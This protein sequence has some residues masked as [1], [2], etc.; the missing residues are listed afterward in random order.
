VDII[1]SQLAI[2]TW[3]Q[4]FRQVVPDVRLITPRPDGTWSQPPGDR[5][6]CYLDSALWRPDFSV[7]FLPKLATLPSLG[8]LHTFMHG[9]DDPRFAALLARGVQVTRS[10]GAQ[11]PPI[12]QYVLGMMLRVA[13]QMDRWTAAQARREWTPHRSQE[14]T[15]QTLGL[16]GLGEIGREIA[17]LAQALRMRVIGTRRTPRPT[18]HVDEVLP[19][20]R[21]HELL[22]RA[23]FVV[24]AAALTPETAGMIGEAELRAISPTAWLI[25]VARGALIREEILVRALRE[26]WFAGACLDVFEHEPLPPTSEL[27][28]LPNVIVTPHN[29]IGGSRLAMERATQMFLDNLRRYLAGERLAHAVAP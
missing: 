10:P 17:R 22:S 6:V 8:W 3:E 29:S 28:S 1:T 18:E 26:T 12:A 21:L 19:R 15:G 9:V 20:D 7:G 23:D 27:W 16:I 14:L 5:T 25:N 2:D 13:R 4:Q 24:L 11:S